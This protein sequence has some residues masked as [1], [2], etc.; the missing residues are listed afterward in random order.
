MKQKI[1]RIFSVHPLT[2]REKEEIKNIFQLKSEEE[3]ENFID[4]KL[5]GGL[6]IIYDNQVFD[7]SLR[8]RLNKLKNILYETTQRSFF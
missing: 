1:I 3:I 4:K 5:I 8:G 6:R 2:D 7:L